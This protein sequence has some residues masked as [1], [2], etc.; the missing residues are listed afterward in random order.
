MDAPKDFVSRLTKEF[1]GRLRIRWSKA[2][3]EW[4]IEQRIARATIPPFQVSEIDDRLIRYRDGY[5]YVMSIRPGTRMPC[6]KCGLTLNVPTM[7]IAEVV[8][9][10]CKF[11]ERDGRYMASYWP[12]G[13]SLLEHLRKYDPYRDGYRRLLA[14][15]AR[16][17]ERDAINEKSMKATAEDISRDE[18]MNIMQIPRVGYTTSKTFKG[19]S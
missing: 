19:D 10:H 12:L 8:C 6:P 16:G 1:D 13:E 5:E 4:M 15:M 9:D 18:W 2:R 11:K 7:K 3:G 14:D 17:D